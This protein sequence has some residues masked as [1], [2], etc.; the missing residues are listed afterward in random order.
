MYFPVFARNR[1]MFFSDSARNQEMFFIM[2]IQLLLFTA[3]FRMNIAGVMLACKLVMFILKSDCE[4]GT[5]SS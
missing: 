4:A 2:I 1:E 3:D 5:S